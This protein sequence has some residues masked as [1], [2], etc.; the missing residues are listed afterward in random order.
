MLAIDRGDP[1]E[2]FQ[3]EMDRLGP[4]EP[5]PRLAVALSGG[6]DSTALALLAREW[7]AHRDGSVLALIVDHG[8]RAESASEAAA[9]ADRLA[10]LGISAR[11]LTATGLVRGPAM[12]ERARD[13]RYRLLLAACADAGIP[14]LLLGHHR[15]DQVETVM[16]R[17]LSASG[18]RGLAGMPA[19]LETRYVRLLRPLLDVAPDRLRSFL[20]AQEVDWVED[21]SNRDPSAL[22]SRLRWAR[23]DPAGTGEGTL[24]V[25]QS[26]KVAGRMRAGRDHAIAAVLGKRATIR[27][28]GYAVVTPGPIDPEALA[29]LLRTIG[30]AAY[31]PPIHRVAEIAREFV[32]TTLGGVRIVRAGRM[33]SGWLLIRER[34]A[35]AP[36]VNARPGALWD[37]RF[38]LAGRPPGAG[39]HGVL[40]GALGHEA[41]R[42]RNRTGP[43]ALVL[44]G[45]PALRQDGE[46]IAVP[47]IGIGDPRWRVLFDPGNC[48]AG[49]PFV[50]G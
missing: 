27:P 17:A 46:L 50:S 32:P 2:K 4:F 7:A 15:G 38:R 18:S 29:S 41:I 9:T 36:A 11:R 47:H 48:A 1:I 43:P 12:A 23:A 44:Q 28:E 45:L 22:R 21:P 6:A 16:M 40:L 34:R 30:G 20:R 3:R 42:F 5:C 10:A 19:L 39:E 49:A 37:G 14:H 24:A 33:G 35:M 31:L 25:V 8:L 26:A 13:A